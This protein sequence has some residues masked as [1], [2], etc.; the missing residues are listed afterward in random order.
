[1]SDQILN[2]AKA[3]QICANPHDLIIT[4]GKLDDVP[5]KFA[6]VISRGPKDDPNPLVDSEPVIKSRELAIV[7]IRG[8]LETARFLSR[9]ALKDS[10]TSPTKEEGDVL[11]QKRID[12]IIE[13]LQV[14][15]SVDT[16]SGLLVDI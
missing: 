8:I 10:Q 9:E 16:S 11:T 13:A 6:I 1:M 4:I 15:D 3:Q 14:N 5:G 12:K 7:T 2:K